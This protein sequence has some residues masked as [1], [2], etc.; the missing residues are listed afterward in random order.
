MLDVL[1]FVLGSTNLGTC[2]ASSVI[3]RLV[4]LHSFTLAAFLLKVKKL[5]L[6]VDMGTFEGQH[7][8]CLYGLKS[9]M[10]CFSLL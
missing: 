10:L 8:S 2:I 9:L 5:H 7:V 6:F 4:A 1:C 3:L